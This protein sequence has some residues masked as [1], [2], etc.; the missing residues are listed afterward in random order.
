M[1][2]PPSLEIIKPRANPR[3]RADVTLLVICTVYLLCVLKDLIERRTKK[4]SLIIVFLV[5]AKF[6]S[7]ILVLRTPV[8]HLPEIFKLVLVLVFVVELFTY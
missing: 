1:P 3:V 7:T 8:A 2:R 4:L 5:Q 6:F